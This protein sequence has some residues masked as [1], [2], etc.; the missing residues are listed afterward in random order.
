MVSILL[1]A[2]VTEDFLL[3]TSVLVIKGIAFNIL[4]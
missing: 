4:K 3:L 2:V 1:K